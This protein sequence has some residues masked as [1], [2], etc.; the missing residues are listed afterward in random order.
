MVLD[1]GGNGI[2]DE[3]AQALAEAVR[4]KNK[5]D[6]SAAAAID[7]A[8]TT[9]DTSSALPAIKA[10]KPTMQNSTQA[11]EEAN[12]GEGEALATGPA[13]TSA[14]ANS[15]SRATTDEEVN[16]DAP[17]AEPDAT[18]EGA[19]GPTGPK[20]ALNAPNAE[21]DDKTGTDRINYTDYADCIAKVCTW[22]V[23]L[24]IRVPD[25]S[26]RSGP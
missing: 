19:T 1:L 14:N 6:P 25:S 9:R 23:I 18:D 20:A 15:T 17:D 7:V 4:Q 8:N 12:I 16:L 10:H 3:G 2:G 5:V 22:S 13:T 11:I 21:K 26:V 24:T